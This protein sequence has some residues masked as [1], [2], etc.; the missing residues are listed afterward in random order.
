MNFNQNNINMFRLPTITTELQL[1]KDNIIE[2]SD[3]L[4][5]PLISLGYHH[6][7]NKTRSTFNDIHNKLK[8]KTFYYI[9]NDFEIEISD[10]EDNLSNTLKFYIKNDNIEAT[11]DFYIMW[12]LLFLFNLKFNT[13][14]VNDNTNSTD[15]YN[16]IYYYNAKISNSSIQIDNLNEKT[17]SGTYYDLIVSNKHNLNNK[18][19]CFEEQHN[20][21]IL[22]EEII[23]IL[24]FQNKNG[25]SIIKI[26]DTFT[27]VTIKMVYILSSFYSEIYIIKP[28]YLRKTSSMRYLIC[29]NFKY[30][31][32]KNKTYLNKTIESLKKCFDSIDT[33]MYIHDIFE[34]LTV[35]QDFLYVT[36]FINTKLL[37]QQQILMNKIIDYINKK[38]YFGDVYHKNK[39]IQI[40]NTKW[41]RNIFFPPIKNL[42]DKNIEIIKKTFDT[43]IEKYKLEYATFRQGFID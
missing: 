17:K 35:P 25:T 31:R 14:L 42:Y 30:D 20:Y 34:L 12:E 2:L 19:I 24:T 15:I 26:F 6:F 29:K 18:D 28:S 10:Y 41:W 36:K 43:T 11:V 33:N 21:S 3:T 40:N 16:S 32:I 9:L 27:M 4:L 37:N 23:D 7:F 8:N 1:S 13:V 5:P 38:D 22:L 39:E